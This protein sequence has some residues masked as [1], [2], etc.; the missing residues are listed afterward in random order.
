M[1]WSNVK[2]TAHAAAG[3][4]ANDWLGQN[5]PPAT[6]KTS[7]NKSQHKEVKMKR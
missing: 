5:N 2:L 7:E 3:T 6:E 4:D 1:I